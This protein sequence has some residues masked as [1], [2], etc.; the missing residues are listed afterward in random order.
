MN[1]PLSLSLFIPIFCVLPV[2]L[3]DCLY[4]EKVVGGGL[5]HGHSSHLVYPKTLLLDRLEHAKKGPKNLAITFSEALAI[6]KFFCRLMLANFFRR[7]Q[8]PL[9]VTSSTRQTSQVDKLTWQVDLSPCPLTPL[10]ITWQVI[11]CQ[12][13]LSSHLEQSSY[14]HKC[15]TLRF[16]LRF[17]S[18]KIHL[19]TGVIFIQAHWSPDQQYLP[20]DPVPAAP[21]IPKQYYGSV[22][23]DQL[24]DDQCDVSVTTDTS[25]THSAMSVTCRWQRSRSWLPEVVRRSAQR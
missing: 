14:Q 22:K 16:G 20:D 18:C 12:V 25:A 11:T 1:F 2:S 5:C 17:S 23:D 24:K 13:D 7:W 21:V 9:A 19:A 8:I 4:R 3:R 15:R 10:Q 6:L